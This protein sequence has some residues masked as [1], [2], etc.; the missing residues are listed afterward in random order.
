MVS[1]HAVRF[2][3]LGGSWLFGHGYLGCIFVLSLGDLLGG[4]MGSSGSV[5]LG[6]FGGSA[7]ETDLFLIS[8]VS[9][10]SLGISTAG[11]ASILSSSSFC[12]SSVRCDMSNVTLPVPWFSASSSCPGSSVTSGLFSASFCPCPWSYS[13]SSLGI[14][15]ADRCD[16]V[17]R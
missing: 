9:E 5:F 14:C 6:F 8:C 15:G 17:G 3:A 4:L 13:S 12:S 1:K 16:C 11:S 2:H 10:S 7:P